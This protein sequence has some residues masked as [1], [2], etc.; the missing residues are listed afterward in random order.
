MHVKNQRVFA[1]RILENKLAAPST[2]ADCANEKSTG[3]RQMPIRRAASES[4][5]PSEFETAREHRN[6]NSRTLLYR[7]TDRW[8]PVFLAVGPAPPASAP[9]TLR[10]PRAGARCCHGQSPPAS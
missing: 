8:T 10:R 3:S 5:F 2:P 4:K 9:A 6:Q 7:A 1:G